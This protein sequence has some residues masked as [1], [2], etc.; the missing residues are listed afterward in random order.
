MLLRGDIHIHMHMHNM[1]VLIYTQTK[2][3]VHNFSGKNHLFFFV[4]FKILY[5]RKII[6][7]KID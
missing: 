3:V 5:S 1:M 7:N 6:I 2:S 4:S